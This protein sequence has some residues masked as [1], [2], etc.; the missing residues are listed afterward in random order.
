MKKRQRKRKKHKKTHDK[1]ETK[2]LRKFDY[3]Y[4]NETDTVEVC[5]VKTNETREKKVILFHVRMYR[6]ANARAHIF[7]I[8]KTTM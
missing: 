4:L 3:T 1:K 2:K 8:M 7:A 6:H 5:Q